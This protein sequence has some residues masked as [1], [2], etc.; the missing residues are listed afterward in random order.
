MKKF[1]LAL[2]AVAAFTGSAFAADLAAR[3]Y[4]KAPP[5]VAPSPSWTG[6]YIF[7]GVGGGIWD[8]DSN[9]VRPL[10][11]PFRSTLNQRAATAGSAPS[12]PVTTGS[13]RNWVAGIFAD[14]QFGSLRGTDQRSGSSA[15][16]DRHQEA[17]TIW[18]AGVR[19]GYL[20]AP[21]VLSYVNAGYTGSQWSGATCFN[22]GC[23]LAGRPPLHASIAMAGSSAAAS[24]TT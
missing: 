4:T 12:V 13:S 11:P 17:R 22:T 9:V 20:V 15:S 21:N 16:P 2:T 1:V 19:L 18:A 23:G 5:M 3:P 24:R 8:A 14:G 6:F 10:R 7:G